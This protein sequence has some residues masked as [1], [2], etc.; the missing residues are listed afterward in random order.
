LAESLAG[1]VTNYLSQHGCPKTAEHSARVAAEARRLAQR[2]AADPDEAEQAG[3][4]HDISAVI[5][6]D[7]RLEAARM[8]ELEILPEEAAFPLIL[9]QKLSVVIARREFNV[10]SPA[11]LSAIGCHTTLKAGA[12]RLDLA[13][14]VADKLEWDNP[15]AEMP[16]RGVLLAGLGRSLE[17]GA[18]AYLD[19]LWQQ[20]D[21]LP[22]IHPWMSA[23]YHELLLKH[24]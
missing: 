19:F 14:F 8:L 24:T 5:P 9:H 3:W 4:L 18:L 2:F 16:Y 6:V 15:A 13:L 12:S 11:V 10:T 21:S 22:C 20:R 17:E 7:R 23:A 1:E